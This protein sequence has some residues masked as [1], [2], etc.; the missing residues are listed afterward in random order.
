MQWANNMLMM[1]VRGIAVW[2]IGERF[3]GS[4]FP[5]SVKPLAENP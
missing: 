2:I 5:R 3:I 4:S 1:R